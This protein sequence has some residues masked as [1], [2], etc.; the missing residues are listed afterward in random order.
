MSSDDDTDSTEESDGK[1]YSE[2]NSDVAMSMEDDVDAPND[3]DSGRDGTM[4]RDG[5]NKVAE[6]EQ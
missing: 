5:D 1:Y 3:V 6:D 2:H 4:E